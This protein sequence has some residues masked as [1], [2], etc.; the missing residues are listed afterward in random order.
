MAETKLRDLNASAESSKRFNSWKEIAAYLQR[1]VRTVQR[2]ETDLGLPVHRRLHTRRGIVYAYQAELDAW[3]NDGRKRLDKVD[4]ST[5][6]P[7]WLLPAAVAVAGLLL[8][9]GSYFAWQY[10]RVGNRVSPFETTRT[11]RLT[12]SGRAIKAAISRDGR[13]I[14]HTEN[15]A[16]WQSLLVRPANELHDIEVVPPGPPYFKGIT[17]SS[18]SQSIY[19]GL[20]NLGGGPSFLYRIPVMGGSP[21]KLKQG[22]DSPVTFA[23]D[24]KRFAFVRE[25]DGASTLLIAD[26]ASGTE[27]RLVSRKLPLVLDYP[28]WSP[29]G[30][31]I[32]YT[33]VDSS[34][35][36][37]RGS[38]A[39]ILIVRVDEH[40]EQP[41][42]RRTWPF[43]KQLAWTGDG[44]EIMISARDQETGAYHIWYVS[45]L[46][47]SA[48]KITDGLNSQTGVSVTADSSRLVTVEE[49]TLSG[50]W[51]MRSPSME[52]AAPISHESENCLY[53]QWA[54]GGRIV[55]EQQV[56]GP[57]QIWSMDASGGDRS[58]LTVAGSNYDPAVSSD[59]RSLAFVSDRS[60][61]PAIWTMDIDGG[62]PSMVVQTDAEPF[63]RLSPDGKWL[64][65]VAT[66]AEHWPTLRRVA[67][68]GGPPIEL[69]NGMWLL[70]S[71]SPD[72]KWIAG[73]FTEHPSGTQKN[74]DSI[75][76]LSSNGGQPSK[77]IPIS[78]AVSITAGIRWSPDSRQ[79][80][81]V[82]NHVEGANI[83]SQP[84]DGGAAHQLTRLTGFS[85]FS[86]D[87][88]HDGKQLLLSRGIQ[89]RDV[90]LLES[91]QDR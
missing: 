12:S 47:G 82:E 69:N 79:L 52:D 89:A 72:A 65:F 77:L 84:L 23:P 50:I 90:V 16:G 76:V 48:H 74:P 14:A 91:A 30:R 7:K 2:W 44:R 21:E 3:W 4:E 25:A 66:G 45:A 15:T 13:Y 83:W 81:Y 11:S 17:F 10:S 75:A 88:S 55:Y 24:G 59:G 46:N 62:N 1:D 78:P 40:T 19:Y 53:P 18:D 42:S 22:I 31:T 5:V 73:F 39:R 80:A 64:A 58:R 33:E 8:V 86:F 38:D 67:A 41:L 63:P 35:V 37:P 36:N 68:K 71:I 9:A 87:W 70:P 43:I 20:A 85:V 51:L 56:N 28:A 61:T 54:A 60:G 32:A 49:R 27:Q 57:R 6:Q 29:D 26:L 34:I